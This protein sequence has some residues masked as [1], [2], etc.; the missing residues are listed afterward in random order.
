MAADQLADVSVVKDDGD[1]SG[2]GRRVPAGGTVA[3]TL[4]VRQRGP[5]HRHGR[6]GGR[7]CRRAGVTLSDPVAPP[8]VACA[9]GDDGALRCVVGTLPKTGVVLIR[10][11]AHIGFEVAVGTIVNQAVVSAD[12]PDADHGDNGDAEIHRHHGAARRPT[13]PSTSPRPPG[14]WR[15]P[16]CPLDA[17]VTNTGPVPLDAI[18]IDGPRCVD[19]T[20]G[21]RT[22][23]TP[24]PLDPG[25]QRTYRC[26]LA[27]P[28]APRSTPRCTSSRSTGRAARWSRATRSSVD[29]I[30]P[31]S[32]TLTALTDPGRAAGTRRCSRSR[33]GCA[34]QATPSCGRS[35]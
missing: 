9:I 31:R 5:R 24:A 2:N 6:R 29:L 25:E 21:E 17:T 30:D 32:S 35:S 20:V 16:T 23:T 7:S 33:C 11:T 28:D 15:A 8:G 12:Q 4:R 14:A 18:A 34:T 19:A 27:A 1:G 10:V 13:S 22:D 26:E 3:Y